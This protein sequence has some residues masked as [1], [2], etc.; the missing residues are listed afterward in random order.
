VPGTFARIAQADCTRAAKEEAM[1]NRGVCWLLKVE[2]VILDL[3][4]NIQPTSGQ[5]L[6]RVL[7]IAPCEDSVFAEAKGRN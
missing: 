3:L 2:P 1:F 5:H 7:R 4:A 6:A